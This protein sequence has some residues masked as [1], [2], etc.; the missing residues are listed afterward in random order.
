MHYDQIKL[1]ILRSLDIPKE[2]P[3]ILHNDYLEKA[4]EYIDEFVQHERS[5][6]EQKLMDSC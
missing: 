5:K 4:L 2:D 3:A 6:Q 1:Q